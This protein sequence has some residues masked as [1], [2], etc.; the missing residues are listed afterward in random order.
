MD[1]LLSSKVQH[2]YFTLMY[3]RIC[4]HYCLA[5]SRKYSIADMCT[6]VRYLYRAMRFYSEPREVELQKVIHVIAMLKLHETPVVLMQDIANQL[7][8]YA[9]SK[10]EPVK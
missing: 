7:V 6:A 3:R 2:T 10:L 4:I 1:L 5:P 9:L 8:T